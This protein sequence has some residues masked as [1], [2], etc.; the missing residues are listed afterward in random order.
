MKNEDMNFLEFINF[1]RNCIKGYFNGGLSADGT[2]SSVKNI[3]NFKNKNQNKFYSEIMFNLKEQDS[4]LKKII[5]RDIFFCKLPRILRTC[6]RTSMALSK[7]LRV[8]ILDHKIVEFFF[9]SHNKELIKNGILRKKYK[10]IY[11]NNFKQNKFI[12]K[13]KY[14]LD[15]PQTKWLKNDLYNWAR[16]TILT[17][18][19]ELYNFVN[20]KKLTNYIDNFRTNQNLTNSNFIMQLINLKYLLNNKG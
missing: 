11:L 10:D 16:E 15:D 5:Y 3:L 8:P 14:Y 13:R 6:D 20:K 19:S 18:H 7:E 2:I 4:F 12:S 1:C 9:N 17:S